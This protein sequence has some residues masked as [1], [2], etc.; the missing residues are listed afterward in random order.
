MNT[1][2]AATDQNTLR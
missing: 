2:K 1:I